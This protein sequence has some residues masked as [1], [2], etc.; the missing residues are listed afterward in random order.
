MVGDLSGRVCLR[1]T[2]IT[3]LQYLSYC[4]EVYLVTLF[5]A[6]FALYSKLKFVTVKRCFPSHFITLIVE[7]AKVLIIS[8]VLS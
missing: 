6:L 3:H 1:S 8:L 2:N 5:A 4:L 7:L